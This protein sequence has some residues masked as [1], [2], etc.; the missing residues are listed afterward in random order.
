MKFKYKK[1]LRGAFPAIIRPIIPVKLSYKERTF[2]HEALVDSGADVCLF[3]ADIGEPLGIDIESGEK[4][5]VVGITGESEP[6]YWHNITLN[7]GGHDVKTRVGFKRNLASSYG[8]VGQQG[9]F[10]F[11]VVK[12]DHQ[13]EEIELLPKP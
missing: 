11:F 8:I 2:A 6:C 3:D 7:I 4:A 12:F 5:E 10:N 1:F 9:F 13:K